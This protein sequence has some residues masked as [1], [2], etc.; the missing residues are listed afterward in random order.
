MKKNIVTSILILTF[1]ISCTSIQDYGE[2]QNDHNFISLEIAKAP[3]FKLETLIKDVTYI[4]LE[5]NKNSIIGDV[6]KILY[7]NERFYIF[8]KQITKSVFVFSKNGK[9]LYKINRQGHGPGEYILPIGFD[10][11][12]FENIYIGDNATRKILRYDKSGNFVDDI[13]CEFYFEDFSY[14]GNGKILINSVYTDGKPIMTLGIWDSND[15]KIKRIVPSRDVYDDLDV[16]SFSSQN[17]FKSDSIIYVNPPFSNF[18]YKVYPNQITK[19]FN[20]NQEFCPPIEFII[21]LKSDINITLRNNKYII[22]VR[23]IYETSDFIYMKYLKQ[24]PTNLVIS[25][26]TMNP[27]S[28]YKINDKRYLSDEQIYGIANNCFVSLIKPE[29][30]NNK[31]KEKVNNSTLSVEQKSKLLSFNTESNPIVCLIEFNQF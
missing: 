21:D 7:L 1:I 22:G 27:L 29:T 8:D 6:D 16:P 12:S 28:Y 26:K 25:K 30:A 3:S 17:L 31:W 4:K 10:V 19:A 24:F 5:V 11:D 9:F 20:F 2:I 14:I 23:D 13:H 18:I 15:D